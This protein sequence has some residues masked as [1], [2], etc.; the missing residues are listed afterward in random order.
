MPK[1]IMSDLQLVN[2]CFK[3]AAL[4]IDI[5]IHCSSRMIQ[6]IEVMKIAVLA[7]QG[8]EPLFSN[9]Q[10]IALHNNYIIHPSGTSGSKKN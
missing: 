5:V 7:L 9:W 8:D 3:M 2:S 1:F 4:G 10:I 6:S